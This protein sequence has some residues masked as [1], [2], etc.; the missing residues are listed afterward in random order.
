MIRL[1]SF[2]LSGYLSYSAIT[3]ITA[4]VAVIGLVSTYFLVGVAITIS[5][6]LGISSY[7][8]TK[9]NV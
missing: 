4:M 2:I 9:K 1:L 7:Q 8:F 5:V 6:V 3:A